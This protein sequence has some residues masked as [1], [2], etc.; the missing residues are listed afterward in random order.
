MLD[1]QV[2]RHL[3]HIETAGKI[4]LDIRARVF[5]AVAH[6]GLRGEVDDHVGRE[7][8]GHA[9]QHWHV[10]QHGLGRRKTRRL[11]QDRMSLPLQR[12]VVVGR[13]PVETVHPVA[14]RQ[15]LPCQVKADESGTSGDEDL[16]H[17]HVLADS[18]GQSAA[19]DAKS[20]RT[21]PL[22]PPRASA[23]SPLTFAAGWRRGYAADCKS[24]KTGSIPV[25]ASIPFQ[26]CDGKADKAL[27][28]LRPAAGIAGK[29]A[30]T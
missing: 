14:R 29:A 20:S 25:P 11:Q 9:G 30:R 13:H 5:E 16:L 21:K 26:I 4:R 18:G 12:H 23:I 7:F 19:R 8:T 15:K 2:F 27:P 3:H 6:P 28:G 22:Q 17:A 24:V 1:L 10:L